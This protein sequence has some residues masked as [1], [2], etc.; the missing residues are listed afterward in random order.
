VDASLNGLKKVLFGS[1][2]LT[3][4]IQT[5]AM[6]LLA[7][8][9]PREWEKRWEGPATP[10]S[11]LRELVRKRLAL[12]RWRSQAERKALLEDSLLLGDLFSPAT[13]I[14]ALRQ[15]T[16]RKLGTAIDCVKMICSWEQNG[17]SA[18]GASC[19]LPC[20][21]SGLV[22]Q[23]AAF[24]GSLREAAPEASEMSPAPPVVVGFVE[25]DVRDVYPEGSAVSVP[26][27][28]STTR[29]EFLMELA[30]PFD[31]DEGQWILAGVALFLGDAI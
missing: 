19:P 22:L 30:M 25:K 8:Q 13:F 16:A 27:Y 20:T 23:G 11:W 31:K 14:N 9:V 17:S 21:L 7:D 4:A 10:Q 28:L 24:H 15:Q 5:T 1:G 18:V 2:L 6:A 3:P 12:M 29:E 26:V